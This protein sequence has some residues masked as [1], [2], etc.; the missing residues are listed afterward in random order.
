MS[1]S[2]L[3]EKYLFETTGQMEQYQLRW[4]QDQAASVT[5]WTEVG[6]Y[7]GRSALAVGL[8]LPS[9]SLLQL[10]DIDFQPD[11]YPNLDWLLKRR[12]NLRVTLCRTTSVESA[13]MLLNTDGVFIDDNHTYEGVYASILAWQSKCKILCGH[14]YDRSEQHAGVKKAVDELC[15]KGGPLLIDGKISGLWIR[16]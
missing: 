16:V 2:N 13:K 5:S 6:V 8:A 4:L 12:P 7:C 15:K 10:V 1:I 11:F 3:E 14:D 9:G